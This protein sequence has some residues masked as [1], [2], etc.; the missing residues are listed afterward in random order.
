[1]L[2]GAAR[3]CDRNA[4]VCSGEGFVSRFHDT[5]LILESW[6]HIIRIGS[7]S[8]HEEGNRGRLSQLRTLEVKTEFEKS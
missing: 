7:Y 6:S 8:P 1:M 4:L 3:L 5:T 2:R